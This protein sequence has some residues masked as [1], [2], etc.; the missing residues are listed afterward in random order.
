VNPSPFS[1]D[2]R[3]IKGLFGSAKHVL[4]EKDCFTLTLT[5]IDW[6]AHLAH[7]FMLISL[8]LGGEQRQRPGSCLQRHTALQVTS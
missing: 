6:G 7:R 4:G 5:A 1:D 2:C 8:A 3:R